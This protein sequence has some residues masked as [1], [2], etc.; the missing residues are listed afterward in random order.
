MKSPIFAAETIFSNCHCSARCYVMITV[1]SPAILTYSWNLSRDTYPG[2]NF[3]A[4]QEE[5]AH[6]LGRPVDLNT[7]NFLSERFRHQVLAEQ[8]PLYVQA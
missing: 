2:L 3:F 5:L 6:I 7:P 4:M 1:R 8:M